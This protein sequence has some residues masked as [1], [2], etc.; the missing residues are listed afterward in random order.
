MKYYLG[1]RFHSTTSLLVPIIEMFQLF[2]TCSSDSNLWI[3]TGS[4]HNNNNNTSTNGNPSTLPLV[5]MTSICE[6]SVLQFH[7]TT[8]T[9]LVLIGKCST[10]PFVIITSIY[11]LLLCFTLP[12]NNNTTSTNR[13]MFQLCHL[14]QLHQFMNCY[15]GLRFHAATPLVLIEM[16]QLYHLL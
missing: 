10:L 11:E 16:F 13:V 14:L 7:T 3:A 1:L 9:P 6:F 15:C 8:T 12:H 4:A 5:L 2:A